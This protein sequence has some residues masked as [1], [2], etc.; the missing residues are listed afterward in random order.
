VAVLAVL[1]VGCRGPLAPDPS[2]SFD[3]PLA[4][5]EE[6]TTIDYRTN[7]RWRVTVLTVHRRA[8]L[9]LISVRLRN[10][11]DRDEPV[12]V[13]GNLFT[14]RNVA[15]EARLHQRP[16]PDQDK[17]DLEPVPQLDRSVPGCAYTDPETPGLS[18]DEETTVCMAFRI[19]PAERPA[20]L[21]ALYNDLAGEDCYLRID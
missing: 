4:L 6:G 7:H 12:G 11:T 16:R 20:F 14:D 1:A 3:E 17:L 8:H 5:G 19:P 15:D 2:G 9:L 21:D 13:E 10:P 18:P